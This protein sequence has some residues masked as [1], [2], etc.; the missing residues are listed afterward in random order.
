LEQALERDGTFGGD[1]ELA[2]VVEKKKKKKVGEEEEEE[3]DDDDSLNSRDGADRV[4]RSSRRLKEIRD[5][6]DA[7]SSSN[8]ERESNRIAQS[9]FRSGAN[10]ENTRQQRGNNNNN[11]SP[12]LASQYADESPEDIYNIG[13]TYFNTKEYRKVSQ[14]FQLSCLKSDRQ[15]HLACTNAVY[16]RTNICDWGYEGEEF[17]QDMKIIEEVTLEEARMF[18]ST[19]QSDY[20]RDDYN[21]DV[22]GGNSGGNGDEARRLAGMGYGGGGGDIIHWQRGLFGDGRCFPYN[23]VRACTLRRSR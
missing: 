17:A 12:L 15:L 21:G 19:V 23:A 10:T 18:R 9:Q 14:I 2:R 5:R 20:Y 16:L 4:W 11:V 3:Y 1:L 6:Y 8:T 22:V 13:T 7:S